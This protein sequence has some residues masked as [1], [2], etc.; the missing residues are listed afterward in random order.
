MEQRLRDQFRFLLEIDKLKTVQRQNV[1]ADRSRRENSAEH[2]WHLGVLV[3]C[4]AE[5]APSSVDVSKVIRMLLVHDI[6]EVDAGD[7]FLHDPRREHA[8]KQVEAAAAE[9]IFGLLPTDQAA[10]L[11]ALWTEFEIGQSPEARFAH[12]IDRVQPVLLHSATGGVV[13]RKHGVTRSQLLKK[14]SFVETDAPALWPWM[15]EVVDRASQSG[16]LL[17]D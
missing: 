13:W 9:R 4:L 17:P 6:V 11:R 5:Y 14:L 2:S 7:T 16:A 8:Q 1:L 3:L 15:R 12:V 10:E